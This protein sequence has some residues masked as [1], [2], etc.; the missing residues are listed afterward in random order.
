V[1]TLP[2]ANLPRKEDAVEE[3]RFKY[4]GYDLITLQKLI[5]RE[6]ILHEAQTSQEVISY[7]AKH[8]SQEVKLPSQ[9]AA[10]A[11]KVREYL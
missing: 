2:T 8:I 7:Y 1:M 10:L 5:E 3:K 11:P 6:Y 9:F 4:E